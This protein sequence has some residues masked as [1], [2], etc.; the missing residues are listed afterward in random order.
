MAQKIK[1]TGIA[2]SKSAQKELAALFRM[3]DWSIQKTRI[4]YG[5]RKKAIDQGRMPAGFVD[6]YIQEGLDLAQSQEDRIDE[7]IRELCIDSPLIDAAVGVKGVSHILCARIVQFVDIDIADTSSKIWSY[8]GY[9][10]NEDGNAVRLQRG[11]KASFNP[12]ARSS[13]FRVGASILKTASRKGSP[14]ID[15]YYDA[16]RHYEG[17]YPDWNKQHVHLA[18]MRKMIKLWLAHLYEVWR[19]IEDMPV[20]L[21]YIIENPNGA[22]HQR[23]YPADFGWELK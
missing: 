12:Y 3:R 13:A 6:H 22:P 10:V 5:N 23:L 21:P 1:S 19:T 14:Y 16:R 20:R 11:T 9:L 7:R 4:A 17:E 15:V 18:S 8:F 2:I